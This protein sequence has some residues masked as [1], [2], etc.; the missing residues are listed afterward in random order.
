MHLILLLLQMLFDVSHL[1]NHAKHLP[2]YWV[3]RSALVLALPIL[4]LL[5]YSTTLD[6]DKSETIYQYETEKLEE[7]RI[8]L[9]D[10]R[11]S[12]RPAGSPVKP[13]D[14]A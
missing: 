4:M 11:P 14:L 3:L 9:I 6:N 10:N 12:V 8:N 2:F 7:K 13:T 5:L 1:T